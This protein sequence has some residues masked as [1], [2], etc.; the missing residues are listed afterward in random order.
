MLGRGEHIFAH[1]VSPKGVERIRMRFHP[2]Q[3]DQ[4]HASVERLDE[5][6]ETVFG[7]ILARKVGTE[8]EQSVEPQSCPYFELIL[9]ASF[10]VGL[11]NPSDQDRLQQLF[12]GHILSKEDTLGEFGALSG[13]QGTDYQPQSQCWRLTIELG[14]LVSFMRSW[15][16]EPELKSGMPREEVIE[17]LNEQTA[18]RSRNLSRQLIFVAWKDVLSR[19]LSVESIKDQ[20]NRLMAEQELPSETDAD[21]ALVALKT[22]FD[23][24]EQLNGQT[25]SYN[26]VVREVEQRVLDPMLRLIGERNISNYLGGKK[27]FLSSQ[28]TAGSSC[29]K[30]PEEMFWGVM[31]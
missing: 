2:D 5:F 27:L 26:T 31:S 15:E 24:S 20:T 8:F 10:L 3:N 21:T 13:R 14:R 9:V 23:A 6:K 30:H 4:R 22:V 29:E 12:C 16:T 25:E 17:V 19:M 1:E 11:T 28:N 7:S 18:I